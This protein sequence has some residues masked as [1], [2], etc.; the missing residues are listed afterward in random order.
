MICEFFEIVGKLSIPPMALLVLAR[1][2][3]KEQE[4]LTWEYR[5][6]SIIL[7]NVFDIWAASAEG[8]RA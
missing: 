6:C 8:R 3:Q 5:R 7:K 4:Y 2:L 1:I